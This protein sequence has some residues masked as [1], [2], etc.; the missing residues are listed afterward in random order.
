MSAAY[1]TTP[2]Y[3]ANDLPHVGHA[4]ATVIADSIGRFERL[5][6]REVRLMTGTDEHGVNIQRAAARR[7]LAPHEHVDAVA[8]IFR[9]LWSLLDVQ[10]DRFVR[11]TEPAHTRAALALWERLRAR[12]DLYRGVYAGSYCPRCEAY[13]QPDDLLPDGN[14][15][16]HGLPCEQV[17]ED[18]WFFRLS[19]YQ[20][21]LERLVRHTDFVQPAARRNE[22][23]GLLDQG[24]RDFSASRRQV[25][26]GIPVP[27]SPGEVVYV[28]VDAL[29]SYLTGCGF[30]D[31]PAS[32]E[33]YWPHAVHI[34]GKEILRFHC[35]Y[36][37]ALLLSAGLPLPRQVFGHGWLTKD[38]HKIS[39]TTGNT[40]DPF[41]LVA[42]FGSD[43]VRYYF[44]RAIAFGQDGDYT[45]EHFL[46]IYEAELANGFGNLVQRAT[47]LL[48]RHADRTPR[49]EP[50]AGGAGAAERELAAH[51]ARLGEQVASAFGRL[52]PH[53]A[54]LATGTFVRQVNRYVEATAPWE[55]ARAGD[56]A[57]LQV[58]L[59]HLGEAARLAAWY[60]AP[61]I[62]RAADEAHRRLAGA[63][64]APGGGVFAPR[65]GRSASMGPPL[66]PRL[67]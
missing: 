53:E 61:M 66:F 59:D 56:D 50:V 1:L 24:L 20:A 12:G 5:R 9:Q 11:T 27:E 47:S 55:L 16:V 60:S 45:R 63:P 62:P 25:R 8:A 44:V 43:A 17:R 40:I 58:V 42:S 7:G 32:V 19:R 15:P 23:L 49:P 54:A 48:A 10:Y 30:P 41:E 64:P 18:N 34:V 37:P 14:C 13:Y 21:D 67:G 6:G 26:W 46:A 38:G 3:Y 22:V 29:A 2:I 36:W 39:K 33:R 31:Q 65:A 51:A 52:A 35:L 57:R 4:Y 28:W